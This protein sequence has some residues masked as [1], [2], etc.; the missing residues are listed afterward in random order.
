MSERRVHKEDELAPVLT[1]DNRSYVN[2]CVELR[3]RDRSLV[4][5]RQT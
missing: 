5:K 2:Q 4:E 3:I 1:L